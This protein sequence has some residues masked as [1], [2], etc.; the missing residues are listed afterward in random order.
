MRQNKQTSTLLG[1]GVVAGPL[2]LAAVLIQAATRTG[3]ELGRHPISLL[4]LGPL[5]WI[6][7]ANFIAAGVLFAACGVGLRREGLAGKVIPV[8]V[9]AF[10]AG[11]IVAGI[12]VTDPGAGFPPGAPDGAPAHMSWHGILHEVGFSVAQFGWLVLAIA[13]IRRA[14]TR[15]WRWILAPVLVLVLVAWPSTSGLSV[16]LLL[17][18][19]VEFAAVAVFVVPANRSITR[20]ARMTASPS[21]GQP[22]L[23][24]ARA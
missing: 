5:G 15:R 3:F 16:R 7:M 6:Q 14:R 13:L 4:S 12:F 9:A 10:G 21:A 24:S 19:A 17:A 18:T 8:A 23:P 22:D 11:L 1:C 20:P 2:F